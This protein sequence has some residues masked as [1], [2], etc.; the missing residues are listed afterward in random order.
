MTMTSNKLNA[1]TADGLPLAYA[2]ARDLLAALDVEVPKKDS[3]WIVDV[4]KF[5]SNPDVFRNLYLRQEILSKYSGHTLEGVDPERVAWEK[6]HAAEEQCRVTNQRLFGRIGLEGDSISTS[7]AAIMSIARRKIAHILGK[8]PGWGRV[9]KRARFSPG[10]TTTLRRSQANPVAKW[11]DEAAVTLPA[12]SLVEA[13]SSVV[14][15]LRYK[16]TDWN[17]ATV[18]PKNA[19]SHRCIAIEPGWNVFFQL[20]LG[21][22]IRTRLRAAGVDLNDQTRN[23]EL[24]REGSICRHLATIDLSAASDSVA[25]ATVVELLPPEWVSALERVRSPFGKTPQGTIEYAKFS[26][27]GNGYTFELESLIFYGLALAVAEALN[28]Q[29]AVISVYGDDIIVPTEVAPLLMDTLSFFGFTPNK[30]KTFIRGAFRESCGKHYFR[31]I[32]VSPFYI[33]RPIDTAAELILCLNNMYRWASQDGVMDPRVLPV[34][35]KYVKF[36]PRKWQVTRIPDG[37]GDGA[38]VG[39]PYRGGKWSKRTSLLRFPV[40]VCGSRLFSPADQARY[41]YWFWARLNSGEAVDLAFTRPTGRYRV[42]TLCAT[43]L[44]APFGGVFRRGSIGIIATTG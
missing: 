32:D 31:G 20:G 38:L 34:Y 12:R 16:V 24:A 35:Q 3:E 14:G 44:P 29:D 18:V 6:F 27:M 2:I 17:K 8:F 30:K 4:N 13:L 42:S 41:S 28:V 15:E 43:V 10:A 36:L 11:A 7:P 37:Y 5:T 21:S 9:A 1:V 26:S 22:L 25:Y 23:Q 40:L 33:R 39:F 19:K